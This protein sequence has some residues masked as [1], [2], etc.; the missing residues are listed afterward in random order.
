MRVCAN[1]PQ[2]TRLSNL[3]ENH[4][5]NDLARRL[6]VVQGYQQA[7]ALTLKNDLSDEYGPRNRSVSDSTES[8]RQTRPQLGPVLGPVLS[9]VWSRIQEGVARAIGLAKRGEIRATLHVGLSFYEWVTMS[10]CR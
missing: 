2:A 10:I 1:E 7:S 5:G 6:K 4:L 9:R 3:T 8:V